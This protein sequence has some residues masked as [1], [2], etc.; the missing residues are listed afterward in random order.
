MP[1]KVLECGKAILGG[2]ADDHNLGALDGIGIEDTLDRALQITKIEAFSYVL[3]VRRNPPC[4]LEAP[5]AYE[6]IM[7]QCEAN[8]EAPSH[9]A[10]TAK[11]T[12]LH[13][14]SKFP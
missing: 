9:V 12:D 4:L 7:P 3:Q 1:P 2:K 10:R 5:G 11:S 6:D 8:G 13:L 14:I